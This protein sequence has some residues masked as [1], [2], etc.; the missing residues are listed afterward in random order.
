MCRSNM[1]PVTSVRQTSV[2]LFERYADILADIKFEL[3]APDGTSSSHLAWMCQSAITESASWP[4]DKLSRC[5]GFVQGVMS[6]RGQISMEV[7][8]E[9]SQPISHAVYA[10]AGLLPQASVGRTPPPA[11]D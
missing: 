6:S 2:A 11:Q 9:F 10:A 5:L 7:E 4:A 3:P 1:M 8:R